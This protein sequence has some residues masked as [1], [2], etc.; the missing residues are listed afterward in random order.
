MKKA[1]GMTNA[2]NIPG[3]TDFDAPP[4]NEQDRLREK[5]NQQVPPDKQ[6]F[7]APVS[8]PPHDRD[9]KPINENPREPTR[10]MSVRSQSERRIF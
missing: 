1:E 9:K 10:I 2:Q 5:D 4:Q 6:P 8:D 7:I 3:D